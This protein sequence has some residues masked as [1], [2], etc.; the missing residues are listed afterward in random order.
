MEKILPIEQNL[1]PVALKRKL[2][3]EGFFLREVIDKNKLK[4]LFDWL[5]KNNHLYQDVSFDPLLIDEFYETIRDDIE[6]FE[7]SSQAPVMKEPEDE[8]CREAVEEVPIS[9]QYDTLMIDKYEDKNEENTYTNRLAELI[10]EFERRYNIPE[11]EILPE[12]TSDDETEEENEEDEYS[13]KQ[14]KRRKV[15]TVSIAPGETGEFKNWGQD[16]YIEEKAFPHLFIEGR[17]GYLS[18]NLHAKHKIGF[19]AYVRNRIQSVDPRFREDNHYIFFLVLVKERSEIIRCTQTF[20]RQA[21]RMSGLNRD[22]IADISLQGLE[23]YNQTYTVFKQIRGST[24]YYQQMKKEAMAFLRQMGSPHL[25]L[26][27]SYAEF[28]CPQLFHQILETIF[29][30]QISK[31]E[32]EAMN[33]T[34]TEKS[35]IIA[36]NVVQ[37]TFAFEKRIQKLFSLLKNKEFTMSKSG[38]K[39]YVEDHIGRLEFQMR[40]FFANNFSESIAT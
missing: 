37:T 19:A 31:E 20:L 21:R 34:S 39:I 6:S 32:V 15:G 26:T 17:Q 36:D 38:R 25:F 14:A 13:P 27:V 4:V 29:D 18:A 12:G 30:R 24:M 16:I 35:R 33:F 1:F 10:V 9:K 2:E 28:Q 8:I 23:R 40:Y 11:D 3:Y 5:K 7:D 22:I